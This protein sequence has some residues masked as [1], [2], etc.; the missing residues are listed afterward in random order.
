MEEDR[1]NFTKKYIKKGTN[2]GMKDIL[3]GRVSRKET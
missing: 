2:L 1:I 3:K